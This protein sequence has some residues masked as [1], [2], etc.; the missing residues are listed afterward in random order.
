M[1]QT[2]APAMTQ[3]MTRVTARAMPRADRPAT[4]ARHGMARAARRHAGQ[5]C[6]PVATGRL[7]S[8]LHALQDPGYSFA[9]GSP[10]CVMASR[11][12]QT[13]IA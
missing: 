13:V 11:L 4:D 6:G 10:A 12:W 7:S 1:T 2:I 3:V 5:G 9:P 8:L